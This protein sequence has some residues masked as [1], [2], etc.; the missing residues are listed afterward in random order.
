MAREHPSP[1]RHSGFYCTYK[2]VA[3]LLSCVLTRSF[4]FQHPSKTYYYFKISSYVF[5][6]D[7]L[8]G[9][10]SLVFPSGSHLSPIQPL[11]F[12]NLCHLVIFHHSSY[13][14][15]HPLFLSYSTHL[16]V[17]TTTTTTTTTT[18]PTTT[19]TT[20]STPTLY[21]LYTLYVLW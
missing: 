8:S 15:I 21:T 18:T 9:Y 4:I 11:Q 3:E 17:P 6:L 1:W 10:K 5:S 19:T 16:S 12:S 20:T 2:W 7:Y 13:I 14:T